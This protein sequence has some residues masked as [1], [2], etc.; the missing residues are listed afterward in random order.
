MKPITIKNDFGY[1]RYAIEKEYT[2]I[3]SLYVSPKFRRK[4]HARELLQLAINEIKGKGWKDEIQI[5]AAPRIKSV[6]KKRLKKFYESMG[7]KVF[8]C[9]M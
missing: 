6:D 8:D 4:G 1:C 2:H 3:F 5:V 7:L 9:Y